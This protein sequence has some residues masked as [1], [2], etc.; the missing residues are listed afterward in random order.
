MIERINFTKIIK[1]HFATLRSLNAPD[2]MY[3]GDLLLFFILP[4]IISFILVR[5]GFSLIHV[6]P[7]L[8]KA[9]AIFAAF[10]FNMLGII[11]N[12]MNQIKRDSKEDVLKQ[13]YIEQIHINISFN[14]LVGIFLI[15]FLLLHSELEGLIISYSVIC[16][17]M[18]SIIC[19]FMLFLFVLT[20]FMNLNRVYI[21]LN[22]QVKK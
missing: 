12:S 22:K 11:Y 16:C 13:K 4:I 5:N 15:I 19:F 21:L 2:K 17:E 7:E 1:A 20:L 9:I 18:L 3:I 10:L 14:I 8:V 6:S